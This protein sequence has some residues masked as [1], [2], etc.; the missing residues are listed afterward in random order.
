MNFDSID[1][2]NFGAT[3]ESLVVITCKFHGLDAGFFLLC[4]LGCCLFFFFFNFGFSSS[5]AEDVAHRFVFFPLLQLAFTRAVPDILTPRASLSSKST[6]DL[7][8]R[9]FHKVLIYVISVKL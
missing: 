6:T 4:F 2:L 9:I 3:L 1:F 8:L 7:A 5:S